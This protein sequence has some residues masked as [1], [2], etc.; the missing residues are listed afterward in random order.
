MTMDH[1]AL[2]DKLYEKAAQQWQPNPIQKKISVI[3]SVGT[4]Q[5]LAP[6]CQHQMVPPNRRAMRRSSSLNGLALKAAVGGLEAIKEEEKRSKARKMN[7]PL[8]TSLHRG[9]GKASSNSLAHRARTAKTH[10]SHK[11]AGS[12]KSR[13]CIRKTASCNDAVSAR[14]VLRSQSPRR[15]TTSSILPTRNVRR[16][17]SL[18]PKKMK[19]ATGSAVAG[20]KSKDAKS[21]CRHGKKLKDKNILR[22]TS[23]GKHSDS[24]SDNSGEKKTRKPTKHTLRKTQS[25]EDG[26]THKD[27]RRPGRVK[28]L[29]RASSMDADMMTKA[30]VN[31][32]KDEERNAKVLEN[33]ESLQKS[34]SAVISR[35]H[36]RR[37]KKDSQRSRHATPRG[38]TSDDKE[39]ALPSTHK[40]SS[41][42]SLLKLKTKA[43]A[44]PERSPRRAIDDGHT[45]KNN[46]NDDEEEMPPKRISDPSLMSRVQ[47]TR[48][49]RRVT[50]A[51]AARNRGAAYKNHRIAQRALASINDIPPRK[52][53]TDGADA[54]DKPKRVS[55]DHIRH[56]RHHHGSNPSHSSRRS[57]ESM[58]QASMQHMLVT[59]GDSDSD[60]DVNPA[61]ADEGISACIQ[62]V[63]GEV[64][65]V[66]SPTAEVSPPSVASAFTKE[67]RHQSSRT[68]TGS[69]RLS[70]AALKEHIKKSMKEKEG[71][72]ASS[73]PAEKNKSV[74]SHR[75]SNTLSTF[76]AE[77]TNRKSSVVVPFG[78][79]VPKDA[80]K[81]KE[82]KKRNAS[83]L[84]IPYQ[85]GFSDL[86]DDESVHSRAQNKKNG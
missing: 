10:K 5:V 52:S 49:P 50:T 22:K 74:V 28:P 19:E 62:N 13:Q 40:H 47:R 84:A 71:G 25:G 24:D 57:A 3:N 17:S 76:M 34:T 2:V 59:N 68:G 14:K 78:P 79:Q 64:L 15:H 41:D 85:T 11:S 7:D 70:G 75:G 32:D 26:I 69:G 9:N 81:T 30:L 86:D 54:D 61:A 63:L 33:S 39:E 16:S 8:S 46:D 67:Q 36:K 42:P 27:E 77:R 56:R 1:V 43:S 18:D 82:V 29:R 45:D 72:T 21:S 55:S 6:N 37:D 65:A 38:H 48:S 51:G 58:G 66:P 31:A 23:S 60:E 53:G 4:S 20:R 44:P 83:F 80:M 12:T 35:M 73:D